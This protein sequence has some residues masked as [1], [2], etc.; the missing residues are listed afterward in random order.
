MQF[1]NPRPLAEANADHTDWHEM[2]RAMR[3]CSPRREK[4]SLQ[5]SPNVPALI[6]PR[7]HFGE[8]GALSPGPRGRA[9]GSEQLPELLGVH[10]DDRQDVPEGALAMSRPAWTGTTAASSASRTS[11]TAA[12]T[13]WPSPTAPA[14]G[15]NCAEA[16]QT[17]SSSFSTT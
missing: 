2:V 4:R 15:R 13:A 7:P 1:G 16:H 3:R 8:D 6:S 12:S 5:A 11:A 9:S 10:A 17:P 14:P